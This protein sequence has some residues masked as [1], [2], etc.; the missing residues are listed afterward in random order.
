MYNIILRCVCGTIVAVEQ[1]EVLHNTLR[2]PA[3]NAH[4][5]NC[6]LWPARLYIIFPHYLINGMIYFKK[7]Y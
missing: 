2:Y 7:S 3:C 6:Q 5:P 4:A 1:Q